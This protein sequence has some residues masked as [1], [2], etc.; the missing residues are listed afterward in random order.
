M[1]CDKVRRLM[2]AYYDTELPADVRSAVRRHAQLCEDCRDAL[3]GLRKLAPLL[4]AWSELQPPAV[5]LQGLAP[6]LRAACDLEQRH[7]GDQVV[8]APERIP[9][10]P[11][12]RPTFKPFLEG[13]E[14]RQALSDIFCSAVPALMAGP[15]ASPA[16]VVYA[17]GDWSPTCGITVAVWT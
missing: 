6:R 15:V 10:R 12:S 5:L 4:G 7:I 14:D 3:D 1:Q 17:G 13:L 2:S 9:P 16:A 11:S 8:P